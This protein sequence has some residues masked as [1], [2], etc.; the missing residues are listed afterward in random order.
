M[1]SL[2]PT[3]VVNCVIIE[4]DKILLVKRN[5]KPF[6]GY[7][8]MP[9]GKVEFAEHVEDAAVREFKEET[10]ID[11]EFKKLCGIASE[12]IYEKGEENAHVIIFVCKLNHLHKNIIESHEGKLRW[13]DINNLDNEKIIPSDILM[14][15]EFVLKDKKLDIHKIKMKQDGEEYF[16]E[17]FGA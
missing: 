15:K 4:D 9:G 13:F 14:I 5:N 3:P 1:T 2:R 11:T 7:W 6:I 12:I 16:V 8:G 17:E 10:N